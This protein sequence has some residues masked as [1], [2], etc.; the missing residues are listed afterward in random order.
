MCHLMDLTHIIFAVLFWIFD[1]N[2][3]CIYLSLYS[4]DG[5]Y[6]GFGGFDQ[7]C[8][9]IG[10]IFLKVRKSFRFYVSYFFPLGHDILNLVNI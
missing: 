8:S 3:G 2:F 6:I 7:Y 10:C 1:I 9:K 4:G 5:M